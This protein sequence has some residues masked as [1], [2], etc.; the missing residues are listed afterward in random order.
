M[1][2][3]LPLATVKPVPENIIENQKRN[4]YMSRASPPSVL[5][6]YYEQFEKDFLKFLQCRAMEMIDG[7]KMV[8]T[9]LGRQNN[10]YCYA[11]E[12]SYSLE[13]LSNVLND[14]VSEG[15]IDEAKLNA[16]NIAVYTPSPL[17][18]EFLVKKEGSFNFD[19]TLDDTSDQYD[20][21]TCMRSVLEPLIIAHVGQEIVD[22]VFERYREKARVSMAEENNVLTNVAISLTRISRVRG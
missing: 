1:A 2:T 18:L 16:F 19:S 5:K 10:Q 17:E 11:K 21:T 13:L 14:M 7:G 22:E 20:F 4:I 3:A 9:L 15:N 6:A 8:L 12:S